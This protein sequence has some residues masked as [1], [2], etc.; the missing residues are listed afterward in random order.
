[1][2]IHNNI[3]Y[4]KITNPLIVTHSE[5]YLQEFLDKVLQ[6]PITTMLKQFKGDMNTLNTLLQNKSS[7]MNE[8]S[9]YKI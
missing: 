7:D 6:G 3:Y 8:I 5:N 4:L 1:M 9:Q 2:K